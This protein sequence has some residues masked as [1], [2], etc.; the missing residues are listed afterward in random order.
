VS[1][2]IQTRTPTP[3]LSMSDQKLLTLQLGGIKWIT[4][5]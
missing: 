5:H 1:T 3:D 2:R 4:M